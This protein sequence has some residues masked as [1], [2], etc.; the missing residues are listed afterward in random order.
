MKHF[1]LMTV[2]MVGCGTTG[3]YVPVI[4]LNKIDPQ[5]LAQAGKVKMFLL[6][7]ETPKNYEFIDSITAW[8]VKHWLTDPPATK[9][10]AIQQ[11][12]VICIQK[13]GNALINATFDYQGTDTFGTGA[14]ESIALSTDIV[15]L[16]SVD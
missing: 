7:Q 15:K 16:K 1:L 12:K 8:S 13:G 6:G 5:V 11:A 3:P 2:V 10:N 4:D 9:G 14:W